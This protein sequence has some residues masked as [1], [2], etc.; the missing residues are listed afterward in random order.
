HAGC[1]I[2]YLDVT[3]VQTSALP[4]RYLSGYRDG[5]VVPEEYLEQTDVSA[6]FPVNERLSLIGRWMYSL[7]P[8]RTI[9][10]LA[11]LEYS[12]CCCR[13]QLVAE[14]HLDTNDID[15]TS[16]VDR[17]IYLRFFLRGLTGLGNDLE[18][19][20]GEALVGYQARE[21]YLLSR[22]RPM[23]RMAP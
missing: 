15:A 5:E 13:V 22:E 17:G 7:P 16:E 21:Q 19:A 12:S 14:S 20:L 18:S 9:G 23:M 6:L 4:I 1:C 3:V 11:G 10:T 2:R 8:H